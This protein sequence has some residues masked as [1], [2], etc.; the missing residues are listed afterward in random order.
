[1]QKNL[2]SILRRRFERAL[3]YYNQAAIVQD[4]MAEKLVN[5]L[6]E[7]SRKFNR[8]LEIGS[9]TG[10]LTK[11]VISLFEPTFYLANDLVETCSL[12]LDNGKQL[13]FVVGDGEDPSWVRGPFDLI[14]SNATFQWF[15]DLP[16]AIKKF[17][18]RLSEEGILAFTTFGP[19]TMQEVLKAAHQH[20]RSHL[21]GEDEII[22]IFRDF[23]KV[24]HK[25]SWI[26]K[27]YFQSPQKVLKHI[28]DT[29][30][31]GFLSPKW[32]LREIKAWARRYTSLKDQKG[33]PVTYQPMLF[34]LEKK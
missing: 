15:L 8:I 18:N 14:V 6:L 21:R 1:M 22:T 28:R 30:A 12:Y 20:Q 3:P 7:L 27:L 5:S 32:S 11:R 9:G 29:G 17:Y 2:K 16:S 33:L 19:L 10:L 25:E 31:L 24:I 26:C 34:I 4:E 23:F 13:Y